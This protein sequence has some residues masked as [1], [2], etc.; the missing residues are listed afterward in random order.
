[1]K[2]G[3]TLGRIGQTGAG[4]TRFAERA[5]A[6][7]AAIGHDARMQVALNRQTGRV[8]LHDIEDEL[9]PGIYFCRGVSRSS[10]PDC[11]AEDLMIEAAEAELMPLRSLRTMEARAAAKRATATEQQP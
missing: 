9:P 10:D 11:I 2:A 7:T 8:S 5:V 3:I 1:M 4:P 6:A